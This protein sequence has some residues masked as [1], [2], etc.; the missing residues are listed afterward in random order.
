M[1][2]LGFREFRTLPRVTRLLRGIVQVDS[3]TLGPWIRHI[4]T[5]SD[6]KAVVCELSSP[7]VTNGTCPEALACSVTGAAAAV[8]YPSSMRRVPTCSPWR[9]STDIAQLGPA[10]TT[11]KT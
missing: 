4:A 9:V 2:K 6:V 3:Q 10:E 11:G 1:K 8:S 5:I 7:R